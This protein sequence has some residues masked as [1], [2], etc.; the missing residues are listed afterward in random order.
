MKDPQQEV[1]LPFAAQ[2]GQAMAAPLS[3][4]GVS[5]ASAA[6]EEEGEYLVSVFGSS[7]DTDSAVTTGAVKTS[8]APWHHPVKQIVREYQWVDL[9]KKLI[10][11]DRS[12]GDRGTLKYFTLPGADLLDVRLLAS[13]L[14]ST[15]TK[16]EYFG[17]DSGYTDESGE[18]HGDETGSY[19]S[20]ESALRQAGR[21][22]DEAVVLGDRL[23][24]IAL[25][26]SHAAEQLRQK[27]VF[28]VVNIDA[29]D[30]L[31]YKPVGRSTSIFDAVEKLLAHQLKAEKSWLLFVT[32]RANTALLGETATKLQGAIHKNLEMHGSAFATPLA[33]CIG[34]SEPTIAT[35]MNGHWANQSLDFLKLFSVGMG[36]YLLQYFHAQ[37]NLPAKVE[38]VSTF[39]YK[40]S[41]DSPDMLSL[42]F[43]ITPKGLVVQQATAGGAA[44][45]PAVELSHAVSVVARAKKIWDLDEGIKDAAVLKECVD[46]T[47]KLLSSANYDI[48]AWRTW[49]SD[50]PVRPLQ[51]N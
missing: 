17:C 30:H 36:K 38:L 47:E 3:T 25:K 44:A 13:A 21:I 24:D 31:G 27:D 34:G 6:S 8:F 29:C 10:D 35:D 12:E 28:D 5:V 14:E 41:S 2:T 1:P 7:P 16:I 48:G 19:L 45:I 15:G 43:R 51:L 49:L 37:Q 40:V 18:T 4:V 11:E 33:D 39:A 50:L 23:E 20:A 22:T 46:S 32:T 9:V 26:G 42:A